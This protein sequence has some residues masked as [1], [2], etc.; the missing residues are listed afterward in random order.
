[1]NYRQKL[2]ISLM[3]YCVVLFF[4]PL[5]G[6]AQQ[7]A[8]A[9]PNVVIVVIDDMGWKQLSCYGSNF[10]K[11][12]NI[13]RLAES[14]VRFTSA[15]SSAPVCSPT[16]A[17]LMT[18]K[19]PARLHL[20]DYIPGTNPTDRTLLT[21]DW[22]KYLPV[23]EVTIA[24]IMKSAGYRTALFGKWHLS[25][26]K[27]GPESLPN[28]PDKQGFHE[29]FLTLK[30]SGE[31]AITPWQQP[32]LDGHSTDTIINRSVEFI[33]RNRQNPF[34]LVVS[35]DA[36]H[37]PLM[38]RKISVE[39]YKKRPDS[40]LPENNPVLGAMVERA[41]NAVGRLLNCLKQNN[42][43]ENTF[44]VLIS[45]NGGLEKSA[46]QRPLKHDKGW[47]YEGGIR[48]PMMV[49]WQGKI[50]P[51]KKSDQPVATIDILPTL[52]D[53]TGVQNNLSVVDGISIVP[54]LNEDKPLKR[55][56]LYW[57]YPHYHNGPPSAAIRKGN[58]KLIEFY[59]K[60]LTGQSGAFELYDLS[61]DLGETNDL[62][63]K[64]PELVNELKN[65]LA[66]WRKDVGAQVPSVN[67]QKSK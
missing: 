7:N 52:L 11:S 40:N 27:S 18:G 33:N 10:Y 43:M 55:E 47:L 53:L 51:G 66:N 4:F 31:R 16:R 42:L 57:N 5:I 21:P 14:G 64:N 13:D 60:S 26:D 23:E 17:A 22:Q 32:E 35:F 59:E 67:I 3:I 54:A 2:C 41:D 28:N 44:I 61:K 30:P 39:K 34:F 65:E 46:S 1:M 20:T 50:K 12:P 8:S 19:Y 38:E 63:G 29:S 62:A 6:K 37:D 58:F 48:V 24:E 45:D 25:K 56:A 36:I 49:S 9:K 15:Y